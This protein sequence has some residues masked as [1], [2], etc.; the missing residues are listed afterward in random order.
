MDL[1]QKILAGVLAGFFLIA[2]LRVFSTPLK[3]ALKLLCNTL[4]GFLALWVLN[5]TAGITG[6]TLGLNL[7]N[8]L[9]VGVLGLPGLVLLLLAQWVV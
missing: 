2:L 7:W 5:L 3:L 6:V 1:N 4:L 8:A 9:V